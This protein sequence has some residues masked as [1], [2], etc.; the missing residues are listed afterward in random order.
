[1]ALALE[2]RAQADDI[3]I[4]DTPK[5]RRRRHRL[6]ALTPRGRLWKHASLADIDGILSPNEIAGMFCFTLVRNPWDRAVSYYHWL[7]LQ[8]FDHSAVGLAKTLDFDGFL[9]HPQT[10]SSLRAWPYGRYVTDV[11]GQERAQAFVRLEH[12]DQD[13]AQLA[14]HLG[15]WPEMP[16][17]NVATQGDWRDHY[18]AAL[19][20]HLARLC[21]VDIRRFGY[22]GPHV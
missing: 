2:A 10:V 3:L 14:D 17:V 6:K 5:A 7:K 11:T 20:D 15:F 4:G 22:Q 12:L 13:L 1:M 21:A 8:D 18:D 9:R 16:H 19:S